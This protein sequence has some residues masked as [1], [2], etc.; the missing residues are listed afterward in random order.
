MVH[1]QLTTVHQ[2]LAGVVLAVVG[3]CGF[4]LLSKLVSRHL[5]HLSSYKNVFVTHCLLVFGE[6]P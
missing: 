4:E 6:I 1:A 2:L 5:Y 3:Y